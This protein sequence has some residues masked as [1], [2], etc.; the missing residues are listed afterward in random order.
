MLIDVQCP[1]NIFEIICS[2]LKGIKVTVGCEEWI[3]RTKCCLR[4]PILDLLLWIFFFLWNSRC[5]VAVGCIAVAYAYDVTVC[6][7]Y[8]ST[9]KL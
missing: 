2:Y 9:T 7:E 8:S 3:Q 4:G 1:S 5:G 6:L